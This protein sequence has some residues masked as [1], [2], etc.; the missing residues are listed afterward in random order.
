[1]AK[2]FFGA[3]NVPYAEYNVI[4]DE[5]AREEMIEKSHQLGVPVIDIDGNIVVGFD[6]RA[7]AERL[8][9]KS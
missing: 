3:H 4:E 9:I 5:K 1:M 7:L 2:E 6:R 8:G